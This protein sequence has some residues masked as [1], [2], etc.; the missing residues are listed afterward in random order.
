LAALERVIFG[1]EPDVAT[2]TRHEEFIADCVRRIVAP[3]S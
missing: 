2:L 1:E 3:R